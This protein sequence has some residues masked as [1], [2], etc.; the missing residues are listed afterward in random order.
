[1]VRILGK[2]LL[3]AEETRLVRRNPGMLEQHVPRV[4]LEV[5][6]STA[7]SRLEPGASILICARDLRDLLAWMDKPGR[8]DFS[9][10]VGSRKYVSTFYEYRRS[11]ENATVHEIKNVAKVC[12]AAT[13]GLLVAECRQLVCRGEFLSADHI[14]ALRR[15]LPARDMG[16]A[17]SCLLMTRRDGAAAAA[18]P[19]P[20]D[21]VSETGDPK[22][23][24]EQIKWMAA[25]PASSLNG[26]RENFLAQT[27]R[28][29]FLART[30][31]SAS[32]S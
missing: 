12:Y 20:N 1:M 31:T 19:G 7:V 22:E 3:D 21:F 2:K 13:V 26:P 28:Q 6:C 18:A 4:S 25:K 14:A 16:M 8:K 30:R 15:G 17:R 9:S 11:P 24:I 10:R 32:T 5:G 29:N 23:V 27:R